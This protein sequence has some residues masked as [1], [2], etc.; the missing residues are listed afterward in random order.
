MSTGI[1]EGAHTQ[2]YNIQ[3]HEVNVIHFEQDLST[4]SEVSVKI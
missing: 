1:S 3:A 4:V 2:F